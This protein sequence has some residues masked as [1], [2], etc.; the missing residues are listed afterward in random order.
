VS[1]PFAKQFLAETVEVIQAIDAAEVDAV[2]TGLAAVRERGGRLFI[3]GVGGS[4]GHASHAVCDFRKLCALEA[5]TPTDN[6][7][8]LTA[9]VNDEGW[10]TSFAAWLQ[11]SRLNAKDGV[12]VFSVGGGDA[13]RNVSANLVHALKLARSVGASV[14]GLVGRDGGYT[15]KVSDACVVIPPL[16]GPHVT[17]HSEGLAAVLWHLLVSN[18]V[19]ARATTK[20]ESMTP[21]AS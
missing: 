16:F 15:K 7:S 4:A 14:Y 17:P 18:P 19:L 11:V 20:W 2:A 3:L 5:Y 9:R 21:K 10:D 13:E 1:A 12:L 8:E 6:A